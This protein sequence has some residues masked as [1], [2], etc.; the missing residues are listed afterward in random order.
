M[1]E[2]YLQLQKVH[3]YRCEF[4]RI[5]FED[6]RLANDIECE[7]VACEVTITEK[8]YIVTII[9]KYFNKIL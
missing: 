8:I 4:D 2:H 6:I 9:K 7:A 1:I 3:L 5:D